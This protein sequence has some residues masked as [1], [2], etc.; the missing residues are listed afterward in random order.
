MTSSGGIVKSIKI[1]VT[2]WRRNGVENPPI[3]HGQYRIHSIRY[4][5]LAD[6][7][8]YIGNAHKNPSLLI[9]SV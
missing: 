2:L 4:T 6:H 5:V 7:N 8:V 1:Y 9:S 3:R